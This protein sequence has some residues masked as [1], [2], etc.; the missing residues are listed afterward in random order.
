MEKFDSWLEQ[1]ERE[2]VEFARGIVRDRKGSLADLTPRAVTSFV[3]DRLPDV[4]TDLEN[5]EL[6]GVW[7]RL[8]C[9]QLHPSGMATVAGV[10]DVAVRHALVDDPDLARNIAYNAVRKVRNAALNRW[11]DTAMIVGGELPRFG[12]VYF[13]DAIEVAKS[14]GDD[15]V[16]L[17]HRVDSDERVVGAVEVC[18]EFDGS[19][20]PH[21]SPRFVS[22]DELNG[23]VDA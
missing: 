22:V 4:V 11:K 13:Q 23:E 21:E 18:Y 12:V 5:S 17:W 8:G 9:P 3:A 16:R 15:F 20:S 7:S 10:L 2:A 14:Y 19:V 6:A 1:V